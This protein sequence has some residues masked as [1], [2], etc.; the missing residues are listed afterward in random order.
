[1]NEQSK[2]LRLTLNCAIFAAVTAI[3]AQVEVPLPLVPISG[4]TL[5]VGITATILG[6]RQGAVAMVCYAAIGTAG[7]PVFAG[8]SG[9][10]QILAGPTGGYIIGFIAAAF[11]TGLI[12][13]K[14]RYTIPMAM[15]A[16]TAGMIITLMFGTIQLKFIVDLGWKEALASGVYPFVFVGLI[17]AF[18]ASW[19]GIT[20]RKQLI[21]ASLITETYKK[22]A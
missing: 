14:T 18:L 9:G 1:M 4:Q 17:K 19:I 20:V 7:L 13:E 12:L 21:Q 11:F 22:T 2:K 10:P 16:N 3:M 5:A 6:S 15:I 8:L